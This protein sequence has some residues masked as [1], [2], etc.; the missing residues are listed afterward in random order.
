MQE[1]TKIIRAMKA[2]VFSEPTDLANWTCGTQ[3]VEI[4]GKQRMLPPGATIV[5]KQGD[6][7]RFNPLLIKVG[8]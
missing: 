2:R 3:A 5:I 1:N 4:N 6:E 7:V 8:K